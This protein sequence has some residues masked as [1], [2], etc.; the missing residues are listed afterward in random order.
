MAT[1]RPRSDLPLPD[2][3]GA[4]TSYGVRRWTIATN[5]TP[6][7]PPSRS[8]SRAA[9]GDLDGASRRRTLAHVQGRAS[10]RARGPRR[11][12][13]ARSRVPAAGAPGGRAP[14]R[15]ARPRPRSTSRG[16]P[17]QPGRRGLRGD[18]RRRHHGRVDDLIPYC[19][20]HGIKLVTVADLIE[21]RRGTRSSSSA[22]PRCGCRP[23]TASSPPSPSARS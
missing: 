19:E 3:G 15:G 14:A 17:A 23:R 1:A 11:P 8:R 22:R 7:A 4:A 2:R 20:K 16:S 18:E 13:P 6:F 10:T 12:S 5:E 9:R 21:Y